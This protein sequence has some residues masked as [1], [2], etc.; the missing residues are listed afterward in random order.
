MG[1][2]TLSDSIGPIVVDPQ[3]LPR[4]RAQRQRA[5]V[6]I[7]ELALEHEPER[8]HEALIDLLDK[9]GLD[10]A[11]PPPFAEEPPRADP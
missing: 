10:A 5:R 2:M 1:D 7:A 3:D 4:Q 11:D 6:T 8:A 9:L